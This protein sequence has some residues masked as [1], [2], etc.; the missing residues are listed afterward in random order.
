M[1]KLGLKIEMLFLN[2]F[3]IRAHEMMKLEYKIII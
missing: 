2:K 3:V 1:L